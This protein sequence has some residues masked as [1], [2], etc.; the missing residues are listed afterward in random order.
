MSLDLDINDFMTNFEEIETDSSNVNTSNETEYKNLMYN[1]SIESFNISYS[2]K[3]ISLISEVINNEI[4]L[5]INDKFDIFINYYSNKIKN[6]FIY[7][8]YLLSQFD[9]LGNNSKISL[10]NLFVEN[11]RKLKDS[12][13]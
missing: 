6:D 7:Y 13:Y 4:N 12:I 1:I 9:E 5:I 10:M 8:R 11:P 3:V 2:N